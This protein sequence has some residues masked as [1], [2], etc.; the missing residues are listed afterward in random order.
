MCWFHK[1]KKWKTSRGW[2]WIKVTKQ[3]FSISSPHSKNSS[4]YKEFLESMWYLTSVLWICSLGCLKI[5]LLVLLFSKANWRP[6]PCWLIPVPRLPIPGVKLL[7]FV[8]AMLLLVTAEAAGSK[9]VNISYPHFPHTLCFPKWGKF[10]SIYRIRKQYSL[11]SICFSLL[12]YE[13][14][15]HATGFSSFR[16]RDA[17]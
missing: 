9:A 5:S 11:L 7:M 3:Y 17:F 4:P 13:Y 15:G 10:L 6:H 16:R 14:C 1:N 2:T 12:S 8:P